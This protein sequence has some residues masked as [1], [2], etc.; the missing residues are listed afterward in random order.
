ML[1]EAMLI[2]DLG[3]KTFM[4]DGD[5]GPVLVA[6]DECG[7]EVAQ[8]VLGG[9]S[10]VYLLSAAAVG[11]ECMPVPTCDQLTATVRA[12]RDQIHAAQDGGDRE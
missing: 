2:A 8:V 12:V 1:A 11:I 5:H 4:T 6:V 7:W 10:G 9:R 3:L